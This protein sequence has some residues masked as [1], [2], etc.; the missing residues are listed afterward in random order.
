MHPLTRQ[1]RHSFVV[2][3]MI[4][5]A[6][7]ACWQ[8]L[9][10][11]NRTDTL[12]HLPTGSYLVLALV[13]LIGSF[14]LL[15]ATVQSDSWTATAFELFGEIILLGPMGVYL[16]SVVGTARYP[17]TDI[18]TALLVGAILG[19]TGRIYSIARDVAGVVRDHRSP[20][21]GDLDLMT[22]NHVDSVAAVI[23]DQ[24]GTA[25]KQEVD[26][27]ERMPRPRHAAPLPTEEIP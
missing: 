22:A 16:A 13:M 4:A 7:L 17:D 20:P 18:V 21:V 24:H 1:S 12:W 14:S 19:L 11:P 8:I 9:A 27:L 3:T 26:A 25:M 2:G 10:G 5:V 6:G 23:V 15:S